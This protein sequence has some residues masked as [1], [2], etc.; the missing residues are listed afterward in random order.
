M[1][2]RAAVGLA[3]LLGACSGRGTVDDSAGL[4]VCPTP[5][6]ASF[7][8]TQTSELRLDA[9]AASFDGALPLTAD[10]D[11]VSWGGPGSTRAAFWLNRGMTYTVSGQVA[12]AR[13]SLVQSLESGGASEVA[14][15]EASA[16]SP[17]P[18]DTTFTVTQNGNA[19]AL[20]IDAAEPGALALRITGQQWADVT[21][22]VAAAPVQLGFLMHVEEAPEL[23][24]D[25]DNWTRRA[26]VIEA[27][28]AMLAAHGAAL[29]LQPGSTFIEAAAVWDPGWFAAREA[30][31]MSWSVHVHNE[32]DGETALEKAVRTSLHDYRDAGLDVNDLN[33]GFSLGIW[34]RM[35]AAGIQ[36]VTA[37]KNPDTQLDLALPLVQPWRPADGTGAADEAAF[38]THDPDGPVIYLPGS[39][40]READHARFA[41]FAQAHL[42]QVRQHARAGFVNTWYFME[43][44]DG[45]G[46]DVHDADFDAYLADG[47]AA[48]VAAI[49]AGLTTVIDPL[50]AS[51]QV[52]Y[53]TPDAMR[54]A[55]QRWEA[56][57]TL[58]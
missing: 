56:S 22:V 19:F 44:V 7:T 14:A 25:V 43:H 28:S 35:A 30:E 54:V 58:R 8:P 31:G 21:D 37:F 39:G 12:G 11:G 9:A 38:S 32:S 48:D 4:P 23:V 24:T 26:R 50:V 36:S 2:P 55:F 41:S 17:A 49:E 29:T 3:L 5:V 1:T 52:V 53:A 40:V 51:G 33:G 57:C 46:P 6:T 45:F 16:A 47:L 27:L 15:W 20:V 18:I 34:Q 42:A 10:A 13:V